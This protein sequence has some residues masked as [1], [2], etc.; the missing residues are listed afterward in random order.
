MRMIPLRALLSLLTVVVI[1]CNS[2][3]EP[4]QLRIIA[5]A[6]TVTIENPNDW[7]VFYL[8]ANPGWL[9]VVDLLLCE[10]PASSCPRVPP[11]E[12]IHVAYTAIAGYEAGETEATLMQ[13]RL[14]RQLDG[15]YRYRDLQTTT[16]RLH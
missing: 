1:A 14:V 8:L 15:T 6:N 13:W 11:H 7:P 3:T 4:R 5:A 2:P 10:D 9:A 12:T 16:L